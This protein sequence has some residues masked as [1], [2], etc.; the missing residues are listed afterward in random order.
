MKR[1][2]NLTAV[3]FCLSTILFSCKKE[4][5]ENFVTESSQAY[6]Y[7]NK[8]SEARPPVGGGGG[9]CQTYNYNLRYYPNLSPLSISPTIT[10]YN[11]V[12]DVFYDVPCGGVEY[13][14]SGT[15]WNSV[16]P[17]TQAGY[18]AMFPSNGVWGW[19]VRTDGYNT[20]IFAPTNWV[21]EK[22]GS[23]T[24]F[25]NHV[26]LAQGNTQTFPSDE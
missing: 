2:F 12:Y 24:N 9:E 11:F 15:N 22:F 5:N 10:S 26:A 3:F 1:I 20:M 8:L 21:I 23:L 18:D 16:Y 7:K 25:G 13:I 14:V 17:K 19:L 4:K 6:T